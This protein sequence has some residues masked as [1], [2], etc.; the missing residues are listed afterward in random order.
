LAP[1]APRCGRGSTR[2]VGAST[3]ADRSDVALTIAST[4][5]D[6]NRVDT[7]CGFMNRRD[8]IERE[9][10][11]IPRSQQFYES[12]WLWAGVAILFWVLSYVVWGFVDLISLPPG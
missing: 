2:R 7:S 1:A 3:P 11:Q 6:G 12:I 5:A 4:G 8:V 10:R 9:D